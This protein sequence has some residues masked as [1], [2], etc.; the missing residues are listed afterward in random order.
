MFFVDGLFK[1]VLDN[2]MK[3][4]AVGAFKRLREVTKGRSKKAKL[5]LAGRVVTEGQRRE[6]F[7]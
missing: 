3:N 2:Q 1:L 7:R 4:R 6:G 5:G